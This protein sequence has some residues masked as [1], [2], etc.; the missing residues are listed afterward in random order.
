MGLKF[1]PENTPSPDNK[2]EGYAN[3]KD[4]FDKA[5]QQAA[6][7]GQYVTENL[8]IIAAQAK[9]EMDSDPNV[10]ARQAAR[11]AI[12]KAGEKPFDASK[13]NKPV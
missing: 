12:Q 8:D 13:F 7:D 11:E 5:E 2:N 4:L 6:G 1:T 9:A 3:Y 10:A